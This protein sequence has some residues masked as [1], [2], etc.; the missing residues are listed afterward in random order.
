MKIETKRGHHTFNIDLLCAVNKTK[1]SVAKRN[2]TKQ[3]ETKHTSAYGYVQIR[4]MHTDTHKYVEQCTN[5]YTY[6]QMRAHTYRYVQIL[7]NTYKSMQRR[8][9]AYRCAQTHPNVH[10][11]SQIFASAH[12]SVQARTNAYT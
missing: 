6:V 11:Y 8:T 5:V 7:Q 3:S 2:I 12:N 9:N 4:K 1:L 10:K